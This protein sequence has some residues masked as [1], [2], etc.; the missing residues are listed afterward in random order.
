MTMSKD[1][2]H[3]H[4]T[5]DAERSVSSACRMQHHHD[6]CRTP[7]ASIY[8]DIAELTSFASFGRRINCGKSLHAHGR[9]TADRAWTMARTADRATMAR[10]STCSRCSR[11]SRCSMCSRCS[12]RF[13]SFGDFG[14]T[15]SRCN[16]FSDLGCYTCSRCSMCICS[17]CSCGRK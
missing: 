14:C 1:R 16:S 11:C 7:Q 5:D 13:N 12:S 3:C 6:T 2:F 17:S 8:T 9:S 4:D 10:R 15:R